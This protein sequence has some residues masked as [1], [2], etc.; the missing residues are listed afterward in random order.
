VRLNYPLAVGRYEVTVGEY[1]AFVEATGH[2]AGN[3]C[4]VFNGHRWVNELSK[5]WRDPGFSQSAQDPVTCV[6]WNDA[7]DYVTWLSRKTGKRYRLLSEA[8]W[9]YAARAGSPAQ[10]AF[11]G[12][13]ADLCGYANGADRGSVFDWRNN[14]CSDGFAERTAPVGRFR[15]NAFG[16]YDML[17][18]LWEWTADCWHD[19]YDGAPADGAAWTSGGDC[20]RRVL[21]GGSWDSRPKNLR[22]AFRTGDRS[23]AQYNFVGIRI[24]REL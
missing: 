5:S 9:E 21:R 17:G 7:Q 14:S 18:N 15:A 16:L 11:N 3:G 23:T 13:V 20:S 12:S 19:K 1:K 2:D 22:A 8:E 6:N 24:A 10:Y 4:Y